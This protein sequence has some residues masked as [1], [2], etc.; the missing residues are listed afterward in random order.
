MMLSSANSINWGRLAPQI[1]YYV[2]AYCDMVKVGTIRQGDKINVCV[3]TGNFGNILAAYIAKQMGL[4]V[5]K[6]ICAS[7]RNNVLTDFFKKDGEYNRNRDFYTTT[8]PSMDILISSNLERLLFFASDFD[9]RMV[10]ELMAKL[11]GEGSYKV[12]SDVFAKIAADFDAGCC[13]DEHAAETIHRLWTE[14]KYLCDT[15]TAVAVRVY[16]DYRARTGDE[17]PT[18]I[19][20]TAS[21]FKFCRAVIEALGGTLEKDDVTQLDVLT[22]LTGVPAPAPLAA[23]AGK[24]P[25]FDRVVDKADILSTVALLKDL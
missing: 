3:P 17:T 12:A 18:V 11:N 15:H 19:A 13:D 7:N 5:N 4:P 23:L 16:E 20:S 6:F 24:T 21:P 25:R 1:A 9:D 2:S 22:G 14:E 8:S 10:A